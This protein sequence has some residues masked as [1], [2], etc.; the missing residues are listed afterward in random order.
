MK[1]SEIMEKSK[2]SVYKA[3]QALNS[4]KEKELISVYGKGKSTQ[5]TVKFG[6]EE[7][8]I[9]IKFLMEELLSTL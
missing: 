9:Q 1:K 2:L 7:H 8:K 3:S 6:S 5:Y 4:L